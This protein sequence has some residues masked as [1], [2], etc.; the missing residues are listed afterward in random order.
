LSRPRAPTSSRTAT[1]PA[2]T[3]FH[4]DADR[5][6]QVVDWPLMRATMWANTR[7][8]PDRR[9]RRGAEFLVHQ[10]LPFELVDELG[11][12]DRDARSAVAAAAADAG[13]DVDVGKGVAPQ[14]KRASPRIAR[15]TTPPAPPD[16]CSSDA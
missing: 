2:F 8:D 7:D 9:R 14:S 13:W 12:Y 15:R 16:A 4:D 11:V 1:R 10:A 3:E 6:D 5:L